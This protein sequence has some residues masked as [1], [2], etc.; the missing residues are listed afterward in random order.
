MQRRLAD[1]LSVSVVAKCLYLVSRVFLPPLILVH[2]SLEEYGIW[3][4]CFVLM[5][6]MGMGAFGVSN[7][8]VRYVSRYE[9]QGELDRVNRLISTGLAVVVA[10]CAV[11]LSALYF[12]LPWLLRLFSISEELQSTA[13]RLIFLTAVV[14]A[15]DLSFGAFTYV[16]QGLQRIVAQNVIWVVSF[17]LEA[18]LI[19]SFL[20]AGLGLLSLGY[21]F[22]LRYAFSIVASIVVCKRV[23]PSLRVSPRLF[24]REALALFFGYG[25]V[26]QLSG[27]LG[28]FLRSIEKLIA[29]AFLGARA[30]GV[31]DVAQKFPVMAT[32]IPSS[33]NASYLPAITYLAGK[34]QEAEA[35]EQLVTGSRYVGL[36]SAAPMGFLSAF[37]AVLL[38]SWIGPDPYQ[39]VMAFL[40]AVF[41]LPF[42]LNVTTGPATAYWRAVGRPKNELF[43]PLVQLSLVVAL[44][45]ATFSMNGPS[46]RA[47]A[48]GVGGAMVSSAV[49]YCLWTCWSLGI[50]VAR[51]LR[52]VAPPSLV[53]YLL[54]FGVAAAL[55]AGQAP[56]TRIEALQLAALA[57][58]LYGV[59]W[60]AAT[61]LLVL[62]SSERAFVR[63]RLA[64]LAQKLRGGQ[65][66]APS[67]EP[68]SAAGRPLLVYALHSSNL[69]G[70]ERMALAT[71]EGLSSEYRCLFLLPPGPAAAEAERLGFD[72]LCFNSKTELCRQVGSVLRHHRSLA[73][74]A[75]GIVHSLAVVLVNVWFRRDVVHLHLVHGGTD[76]RLSYGRKKLLRRWKIKLVA[77]SDFV[78]ERLLAHG[79]PEERIAV[80][81]N[82]LPHSFLESAPHRPSFE[83]DGVRRVVVVSRV[84]PIKR[85]DLLLDAFDQRPELGDLQVDVYGS[86]WDLEALRERAEQD[87][88]NVI[89]HGFVED[90]HERLVAADLLLHLCPVEPFGLVILEAMAVGVPVLVPDRGG[91]GSLVEDGVSGFKF[92]ANS[93]E[94]LGR[95]LVELRGAEATRLEGV[96]AAARRLL[97]TRYS[98][99]GRL[100]EYRR[101]LEFEDAA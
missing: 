26:V 20:T 30:T 80:V 8:Y 53:P 88:S 100:D 84:D 12:T 33:M 5:S 28:M 56:A 91:A 45:G 81:E 35:K 47:I 31:L 25:A 78:R 85:V 64:A 93:I 11:M 51:F 13:F 36:M 97:A 76:E 38:I 14:F 24:D 6:Y 70:T 75:T 67:T 32:S 40:L 79:V 4:I 74:C 61:Y 48:W 41:T 16:L 66:G 57:G 2:V 7:V 89:F 50:P 60:L 87:H 94:D 86:G 44:V 98:S 46:L 63:Q 18:V 9:A 37:P 62:R 10:L 96:R 1:N 99:D 101:L 68:R 15:L 82:F 17:L 90:V 55:G 54:G 3:S 72:V 95:R 58:S 77:V 19:V 22:L 52:E 49:S 34:G 42:Q 69:Y 43:Y 83:S 92:S 71:A 27:L 59:S 65:R 21:A 39:P 29:G 23:L 73:F